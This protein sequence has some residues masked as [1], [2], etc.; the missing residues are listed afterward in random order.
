M[1][2]SFS[3]STFKFSSRSAK[4]KFCISISREML[5][6]FGRSS[7]GRIVKFFTNAS[8]RVQR[9]ANTIYLR[10]K[11]QRP[12]LSIVDILAKHISGR[13]EVTCDSCDIGD[14]TRIIA[15]DRRQRSISYDL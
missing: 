5:S 1:G 2:K 13:P 8:V 15:I 11:D 14:V 12:D 7:T 9:V 4:P 6:I 3:R 10:Q